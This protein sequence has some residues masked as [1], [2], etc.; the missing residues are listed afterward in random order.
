MTTYVWQ[1]CGN[2][3]RP[4]GAE[5]SKFVRARNEIDSPIA[6]ADLRQ[7]D[8]AAYATCPVPPIG[9]RSC[10]CSRERNWL[11]VPHWARRVRDHLAIAVDKRHRLRARLQRVNH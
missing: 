2:T 3:G 6:R 7:F 8:A 9:Q 5:K 1:G 10:R 11:Q 4:V